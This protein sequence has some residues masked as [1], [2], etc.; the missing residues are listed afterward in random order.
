MMKTP[1]QNPAPDTPT[2]LQLC[3][4]LGEFEGKEVRF[5]NTWRGC[6]YRVTSLP[7][8]RDR[9]NHGWASECEAFGYLSSR[10]ALW[11]VLQK[12]FSEHYG[13][14]RAGFSKHIVAVCSPYN[15][16]WDDLGS[17]LIRAT[18]AQ[19]ALAAWRTIKEMERGTAK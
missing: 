10:D 7:Y 18:P 9:D 6:F 17:Y 4:D 5:F 11:P 14:R 13:E 1:Q 8:C 3:R 2:D 19:L 15:P 16:S 12:M